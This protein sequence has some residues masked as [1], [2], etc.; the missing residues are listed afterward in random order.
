MDQDL[1]L[2]L[3]LSLFLSLSLSLSLFISFSLFLSFFCSLSPSLSRPLQSASLHEEQFASFVLGTG[4][5]KWLGPRERVKERER[6]R[7]RK[8]EQIY[9]ERLRYLP[10]YIYYSQFVLSSLTFFVPFF[11]IFIWDIK[12]KF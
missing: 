10:L 1:I 12:N 7:E 5:L 2:S 4:R 6:E 8:R 9:I 3:S 11:C